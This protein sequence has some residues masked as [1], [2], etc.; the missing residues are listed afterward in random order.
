MMAYADIWIAILAGAIVCTLTG[1]AVR[2][3]R[4]WLI[5]Q[6]R[7]VA[8]SLRAVALIGIVIAPLVLGVF[9]TV[10]ITVSSHGALIDLVRHHCHV[11]TAGCVAHTPA[12]ST[13]VL[14]A[15]GGGLVAGLCLWIG[16]SVLDHGRK[17][18]D[19]LRLL[20]AASHRDHNRKLYILE[21]DAVVA[22]ASGLLRPRLFLSRGL[23]QRLDREER[24][25]VRLHEQAHGRRFDNL[26]R[27]VAAAFA[28][29]HLPRTARL[30]RGE[31]VLAQEQACDRAAARRFGAI[32]TAETLLKVERLQLSRNGA[33][34]SPCFGAAYVD[35]PVAARVRALVA[36]DFEPVR[37]SAAALLGWAAICL[38]TIMLGAEPLHHKI[39]TLI[40]FLQN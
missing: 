12:M 35:A 32:R 34:P 6:L 17:S 24:E 25:I 11:T 21:T 20:K 3:A 1:T 5:A 33:P 10:F 16:L 19:S 30:L 22:L 14:M 2:F 15:L 39:E 9:A 29:G 27:L 18:A 37:A 7:R 13:G 36:P 26:T 38:A 4:V 31:L 23:C 8:P 40:L 28:I